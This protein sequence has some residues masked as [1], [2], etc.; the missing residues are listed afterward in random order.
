MS[1]IADTEDAIVNAL[2]SAL[3]SVPV[4]P[5]F[6][7]A[8]EASKDI[9]RG[10][11]GVRVIYTD[12]PYYET[13]LCPSGVADYKTEHFFQ[14][15]IGSRGLRSSEAGAHGAYDIIEKAIDALAGLQTPLGRTDIKGVS[16][17]HIS[18]EEGETRGLFVYIL[19][20]VI[21]GTYRK[22]NS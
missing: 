18:A 1:K 8:H 4:R 13:G 10:S 15:L 7:P 16:F 5:F 9:I 21:K 14:V 22:P 17:D 11:R 20:I 6:G 19:F 12:S 2:S 3:P